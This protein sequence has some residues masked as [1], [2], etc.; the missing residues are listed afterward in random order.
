[1]FKDKIINT[2]RWQQKSITSSTGPSDPASAVKWAERA[3]ACLPQGLGEHHAQ[4]GWWRWFINSDSGAQVH[5]EERAGRPPELH[6]HEHGAAGAA[7]ASGKV[8]SRELILIL[9]ELE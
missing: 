7:S 8:D 4:A 1:M 2:S 5:P 3:L 9:N 6:E